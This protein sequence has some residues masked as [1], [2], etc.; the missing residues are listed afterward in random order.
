MHESEIPNETW[1]PYCKGLG[2]NYD[3]EECTFCGGKGFLSKQDVVRLANR[4]K[5]MDGPRLMNQVIDSF[6]YEGVISRKRHY[7]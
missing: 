2:S 4:K 1:C 7:P 6:D 5:C 3:S